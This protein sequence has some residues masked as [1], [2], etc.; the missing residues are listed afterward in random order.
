MPHV[1][2]YSDGS[3][4]FGSEPTFGWVASEEGERVIETGSGVCMNDGSNNVAGEICGAIAAL[5][6]AVSRGFTQVVL[7]ADLSSLG[8]HFRRRE[9]VKRPRKTRFVIEEAARWKLAHPEVDVKFVFVRDSQCPLL[10][11]AHELARSAQPQAK[12]A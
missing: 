12:A 11:R 9:P 7:H 8:K 3:F 10:R 6:W 4:Y 5:V 2:L 1:K